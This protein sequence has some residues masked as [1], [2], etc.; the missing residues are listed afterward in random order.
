[1]T[2]RS[3]IQ[4]QFD[5][6]NHP[7]SFRDPV[8]ICQTHEMDRVIACLAEVENWVQRGYYAAGFV[9]YEAASAFRPYLVTHP[10]G[11]L[12]LIW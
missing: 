3:M 8:H 1:M 9:S 12:P 11:A 2:F 6:R 10:A 4:L 5:F 7:Y